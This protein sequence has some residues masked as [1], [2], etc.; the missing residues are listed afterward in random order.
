[1]Q[2]AA[3]V[4]EFSVKIP[5]FYVEEFFNI[6]K[7]SVVERV[8]I[9]SADCEQALRDA[10]AEAATASDELQARLDAARAASDRETEHAVWRDR[11][12]RQAACQAKVDAVT[13]RIGILSLRLGAFQELPSALG[14][15]FT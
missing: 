3:Q 8:R 14:I 5:G 15:N 2:T 12:I 4:R 9:E 1:V 7:D 10:N 6:F 11:E 13:R